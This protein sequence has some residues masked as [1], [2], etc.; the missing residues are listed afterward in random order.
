MEKTTANEEIS[1]SENDP[2]F[3]FSKSFVDL[4][5]FFQLIENM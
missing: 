3:T 4:S 2:Y 5:S 1:L